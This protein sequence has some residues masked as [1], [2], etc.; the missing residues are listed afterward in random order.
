MSLALGKG[1]HGLAKLPMDLLVLILAEYLDGD[2]KDMSAMDIA[3]APSVREE[4]LGAL[5]NDAF[6]L[7]GLTLTEANVTWVRERGTRLLQLLMAW[8]PLPSFEGLELMLSTVRRLVLERY[9]HFDD[10]VSESQF[11]QLLTMIPRLESIML[12]RKQFMNT[13]PVMEHIIAHRP[14][15]AL[16]SISFVDLTVEHFYGRQ[17]ITDIA[18]VFKST[19]EQLKVPRFCLTNTELEALQ[20]CKHLHVLACMLAVEMDCLKSFLSNMPQLKDLEIHS[21]F[22]VLT[23][24]AFADVADC[25]RGL[26][27]LT[28]LEFSSL[29][30][31][32]Q[33]SKV[34]AILLKAC[35]NLSKLQIG[36]T[37]YR[38]YKSK[39]DES[40]CCCT[41]AV[42]AYTN[43]MFVQ[44]MVEACPFPVLQVQK[45]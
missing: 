45:K 17:C 43:P 19:L 30:G 20:L 7:I 23:V 3:C 39:R 21:F 2:C 38:V 31:D 35:P 13:F 24:E 22:S 42:N 6:R 28:I 27:F 25:F 26:L 29:R 34:V 41:L 5:S 10:E 11:K 33:L 8:G 9:N 40:K 4:F 36:E 14:V 16:R 18:T 32:E 12:C 15:F 44:M 1:G 37:Y